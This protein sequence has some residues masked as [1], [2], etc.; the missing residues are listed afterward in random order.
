MSY[1]EFF[2]WIAFLLLS[3]AGFD[4]LGERLQRRGK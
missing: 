4:Y 2:G 1:A 3:L